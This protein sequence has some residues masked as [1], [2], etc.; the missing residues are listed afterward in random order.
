MKVLLLNPPICIQD[1]YGRFAQLASFQPPTGLAHLAG[2]LL[3][4]GHEVEIIDA[5]CLS[6]TIEDIVKEIKKYPPDLVGLYTISYN[7]PVIEKLSKSIREA[8]PTLK[9]VA[10]GPHA[11]FMPEQTLHETPIDFCVMGEGEE[12]LHE[13]VEHL[14]VG[15][16]DFSDIPGMAYRT[17]EGEIKKNGERVRV[18]ELDD[19]PYPAIHLL[20]PLHKYKLYLLHHKRTPYFSVASSRGCPYKCVFCETPSGKIVRAHSAEYTADYLQFLEKKHGVK[21][22]HFVD[23]TFTLNEKRIFKLT[24]LMHQKNI[25]LSWYGTAHANVKNMDVFKAMKSAGCWI[26]AVGI[27]SGSQKVIDMLD[28]GTTK[29]RMKATCEGVLAAGLKL[30]TF[31]VLG[32]P[33]DTVDTIDETIEFAKSLKGHFPVF[34]LMTPYPG[35][36]LYE[37]AEKYGIFDRSGF[38]KLKI[39]TDDPVFIPFGLTKEIL[40]KKQKQAFRDLYF[41]PA[42]IFRHLVG[43]SSPMDAIKLTKAFKAY[44]AAQFT[45]MNVQAKSSS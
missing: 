30:K 34:S 37:N 17:L 7:Y 6:I 42:M 27:E 22:I 32:N 23:D 2:Y 15:A 18:K 38:D 45:F 21:E 10:G 13:L 5:N 44:L 35:A 26:A 36:P 1:V 19:L 28:K 11:T 20:P 4:Y 9:M 25:D 3:Q 31:F 14:E 29:E 33:G 24:E 40:I 16:K 39:A 41:N 8:V 43:L 12:T